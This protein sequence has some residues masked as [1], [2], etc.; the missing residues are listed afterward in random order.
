MCGLLAHGP[1]VSARWVM[2]PRLSGE[3]VSIPDPF[4]VMQPP[5]QK[6]K[7]AEVPQ[8]SCPTSSFLPASCYADEVSGAFQYQKKLKPDELLMLIRQLLASFMLWPL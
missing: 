4:L 5:C 1:A 6:K 2:T 8:S 3:R 7:T